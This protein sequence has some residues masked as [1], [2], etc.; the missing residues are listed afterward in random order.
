MSM[1]WTTEAERALQKVPLFV[2]RRVRARV[3]KEALAA[4]RPVVG[5]TDLETTRKRYLAG[6]ASEIKGY[7]LEACFGP[8]GCPNRIAP[9]EEPL[10]EPLEQLLKG[11]DLVGFLRSRGVEELKFHH[12]FRVTL[13]D[14][15]NACSQPQIK[16]VGIIAALYPAKADPPCTACEACVETCREQAVSLEGAAPSPRV[17]FK[18]CLGCGQCIA[19]CPSGTLSE[20]PKGY[21]IL[22]GG[23]LGRH[24]RLARE[25]PGLYDAQTVL[26][27]VDACL[28]LYK[29]RN[30][31]GE[32][33][34]E[35][36]EDA[37]IARLS[38][39]F[40]SLS[41]K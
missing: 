16:D 19:A 17:D 38:E 33:F 36:I 27:I 11:A 29:S 37:D 40:H 28:R 10:A 24:P 22:L 26:Q 20:G 34:G 41:V 21:R 39:Q 1:Q 14:C 6:M 35:L 9:G 18:R 3:E 5:L 15:P 4:G 7:Q 32:R 30:T 25:L 31:R 12:E 23:K 13:A 8:S 2:R